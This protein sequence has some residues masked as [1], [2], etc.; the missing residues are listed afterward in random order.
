DRPKGEIVIIV[1]PPQE[2]EVTED[3]L[4]LALKEALEKLSV[5]EAVASVTFTT[6]LKRKQVYARA[7]ELS[8][9]K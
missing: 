2:T 3:Q 4:D 5:K 7:L 1:G 9:R 8:G 6:G